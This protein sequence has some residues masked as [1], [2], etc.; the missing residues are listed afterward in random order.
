MI[1]KLIRYWKTQF[2]LFE[3]IITIITLLNTLFALSNPVTVLHISMA[4]FCAVVWYIVGLHYK[5]NNVILKIDNH[6]AM[7]E[8]ANLKLVLDEK[9]GDEKELEEELLL[10]GEDPELEL[11]EEKLACG[12]LISDG[13]CICYTR[14]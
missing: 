5:Y 4:W 13:D 8:I 6:R 2:T 7:V 12:C 1:P 9:D 3:K 11:L 10:M 14:K